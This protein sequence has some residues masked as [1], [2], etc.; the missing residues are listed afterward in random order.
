MG[1]GGGH[2]GEKWTGRQPSG[3][4]TCVQQHNTYLIEFKFIE[5]LE[6]LAI[7]IFVLQSNVMLQKTIQGKLALVVD[8]HFHR[9]KQTQIK[10]EI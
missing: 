6:Q 2:M 10:Y 9:L 8:E 3:I 1:G 4:K 7:L 5:K